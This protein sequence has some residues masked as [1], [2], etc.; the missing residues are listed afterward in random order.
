MDFLERFTTIHRL[1]GT[2][3]RA[4]AYAKKCERASGEPPAPPRPLPLADTMYILR[5]GKKAWRAM[6]AARLVSPT[7]VPQAYADAEQ[8]A[9]FE[10][11]YRDRLY[12]LRVEPL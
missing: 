6:R 3:R 12:M 7:D 9:A 8:Q 10:A 2:F 4:L 11:V 1:P 5:H